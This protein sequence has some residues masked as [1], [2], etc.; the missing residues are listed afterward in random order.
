MRMDSSGLGLDRELVAAGRLFRSF[1]EYGVLGSET[2]VWKGLR[3][4]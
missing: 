4:A 3:T 2:G 1:H